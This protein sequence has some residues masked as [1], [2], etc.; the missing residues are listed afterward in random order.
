MQ[1]LGLRT[2]AITASAP[3]ASAA[4]AVGNNKINLTVQLN[5]LRQQQLV[6]VFFL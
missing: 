6:N 5:A 3:I 2:S 4:F 1:L